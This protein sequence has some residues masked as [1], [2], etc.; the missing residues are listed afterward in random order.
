MTRRATTAASLHRAATRFP[1][2]AFERRVPPPQ[3]TRARAVPSAAVLAARPRPRTGGATDMSRSRSRSRSSASSSSSSSRSRSRDL[4]RRVAALSDDALLARR[5]RLLERI[6]VEREI[7]R[8]AETTLKR[9]RE[10]ASDEEEGQIPGDARDAPPPAKVA[11]GYVPPHARDRGGS[12][13]KSD[14]TRRLA[15]RGRNARDAGDWRRREGEKAARPKLPVPGERGFGHR[16][17]GVGRGRAVEGGGGGRETVVARRAVPGRR[18]RDARRWNREDDSRT[19]TAAPR[20]EDDSRAST[21]SRPGAA[22]GEAEESAARGRRARAGPGAAAE[23][24]VAA[25]RGRRRRRRRGRRHRSHPSRRQPP[26]QP[27]RRSPPRPRWSKS[28]SRSRINRTPTPRV[29]ARGVRRRPSA[30][31]ILLVDRP[32]VPSPWSAARRIRRRAPTV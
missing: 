25:A 23:R 6:D 4:A 30:T 3:L 12:G 31:P 9:A 24:T 10:E 16:S 27:R 17:V 1:S 22:A 20:R 14:G 18:R 29:E 13:E 32:D 26:P 19:R 11:R 7:A 15:T 28:R 21:R 8:R 5:R 2:V